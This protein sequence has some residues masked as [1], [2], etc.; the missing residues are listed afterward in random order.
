MAWRGKGDKPYVF[1]H[2]ETSLDGKIMGR[3]WDVLGDLDENPFY[4]VAFGP[5]RAWPMDGWI[6][7][8]VTTD[9][10]FTDHAEPALPE[11]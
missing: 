1:C 5:D 8:R 3:F 4:D 9:D 11:A 10:N 6:S 2:M 7:G